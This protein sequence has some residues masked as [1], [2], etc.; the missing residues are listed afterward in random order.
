MVGGAV[1][2]AGGRRARQGSGV[3]DPSGGAAALGGVGQ[4]GRLERVLGGARC[5]CP[6]APARRCGRARPADRRCSSAPS[7]PSR[8]S[9]VRGPMIVDVTAGCSSVQARARWGSD[10]PASPA[11]FSSSSTR[12]SLRWLAGSVG[13]NALR[14]AAGPAG[15]ERL[16][17]AASRGTCRS[18]S[19]RSAGSTRSRPCRS[20]GTTG[21]QRRARSTARRS[22]TA[23]ARTG[24]ARGRAARPSTGPRRSGRPGTST[25]R[26]RGSCPGGRGRSARRASRRRRWP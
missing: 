24:S 2:R 7:T 16:G 5:R 23:A 4:P 13:S 20:A 12:S 10:M 1:G 18:A 14:H 11:S 25:S 3:G 15:R 26:T 6:A 22:S 9:I 21:Q 17:L 8:C 19:R